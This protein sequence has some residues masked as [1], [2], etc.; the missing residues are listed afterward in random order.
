[1]VAN[2]AAR[3]LILHA[4]PESS[5]ERLGLQLLRAGREIWMLDYQANTGPQAAGAQL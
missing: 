1:M 2:L 5:T 3:V 4:V